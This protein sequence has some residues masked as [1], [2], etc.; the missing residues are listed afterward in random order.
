MKSIVIKENEL[1]IGKLN[2]YNEDFI[3]YL[4]VDD[5]TL[6][7]YR[8]GINQFMQYLE[9]NHIKQPTRN[10]IIAFRD[11]LRENYSSC[12]VNSYM[13]SIKA[14]FKY[15][16]LNN[17]YENIT[18]DIKGAKYS[19]TPKKQV[20]SLEQT[21]TIYNSLIDLREKALFGLMC[22]TGVRVCEVAKAN[23]EDIKIHNGEVVLF[24]LRKK[25]S[26]KDE[27]VKLSNQ[28]L[29]DI[30]NYIGERTSGSIFI[31]TSNNSMNKPMSTTS[32]RKEIKRIFKRFG[33]EED[34]LS[35]HSLRRT[36]ACI[37]YENGSSIYDIKQVLS[38]QNIQTTTRY[39]QQVDRDNNKT[40]L[41]VANMIFGG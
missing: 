33:L 23:I 15:L 18:R 29:N 5:L 16:E 8:C 13:T 28:T 17:K 31:S 9:D 3:S 4:D 41:N 27:Y 1:T 40:E 2:E 25:H 30:K 38:H 32:L 21:K 22:S 39:L 35:C 26:E 24:L 6:R 34:T 37:S 10:S 12:T 19:T 11:Y 7:A 14:L 20:L 36:F